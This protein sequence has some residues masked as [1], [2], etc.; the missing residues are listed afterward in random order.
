[1]RKT[2]PSHASAVERLTRLNSLS[3]FFDSTKV[4]FPSVGE[5]IDQ[6]GPAFLDQIGLKKD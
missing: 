1:M 3:H 4:V 2:N 6:I 5:A